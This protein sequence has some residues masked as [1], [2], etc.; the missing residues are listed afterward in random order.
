MRYACAVDVVE[1]REEQQP[2]Q[3]AESRPSAGRVARKAWEQLGRRPEVLSSRLS[4]A[5]RV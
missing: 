3:N 2:W 1:R 4:D 5:V